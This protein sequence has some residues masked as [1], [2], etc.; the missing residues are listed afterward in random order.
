MQSPAAG[1]EQPHVMGQVEKVSL[2]RRFWC[3]PAV[4]KASHILSHIS[5]STGSRSRDIQPREEKVKTLI[6]II[7]HQVD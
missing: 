3:S 6:A 2:K 4:M 5:N 1:R 7:T